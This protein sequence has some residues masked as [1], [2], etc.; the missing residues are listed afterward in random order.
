MLARQLDRVGALDDRPAVDLADIAAER[1]IVLHPAQTALEVDVVDKVEA[2]Q[3]REEDDIGEGEAVAEDPALGGEPGLEL[4]ELGEEHVDDLVVD[5]LLGGEARPVDPVEQRF[6]EIG[7]EVV[8][9]LPEVFGVEVDLGVGRPRA[10]EVVE[11]RRHLLRLIVE[12]PSLARVPEHRRRALGVVLG[13]AQEIDVLQRRL[14]V[15]G[16]GVLLAEDPA[17]LLG[18]LLDH[19]EDRVGVDDGDGVAEPEHVEQHL[20]AGR[21]GAGVGGVEHVAIGL[22]ARRC[23]TVDAPRPLPGPLLV[24]ELG[25]PRE[26]LRLGGRGVALVCHRRGSRAGSRG[27]DEIVAHPRDRAGPHARSLWARRWGVDGRDLAGAGVLAAEEE[28]RPEGRR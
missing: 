15:E 28:S 20:H 13:V 1:G 21:P 9:R 16:V 23:F 25:L 19:A 10:E 24:V 22:V 6:V 3:R 27:Y 14:A 2:P 5:L 17:G 18:V 7:V 12:H 4:V 11:D 26:G 8:D